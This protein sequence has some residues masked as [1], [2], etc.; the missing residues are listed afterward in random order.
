MAFDYYIKIG[1]M[2]PDRIA[3]DDKRHALRETWQDVGYK[4]FMQWLSGEKAQS[5]EAPP[6]S[7]VIP[8]VARWDEEH[9]RWHLMLDWLL[10]S[11]LADAIKVNVEA[12][13]AL[14]TKGGDPLNVRVPATG[15]D[16]GAGRVI[17]VRDKREVSKRTT[18][19]GS[20]TPAPST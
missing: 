12:L 9:R 4:L 5:G 17:A 1:V 20:E 3:L 6:D 7:Q 11:H 19:K 18:R 8:S 2:E 14:G 16:P 15:N 13:Y 10:R